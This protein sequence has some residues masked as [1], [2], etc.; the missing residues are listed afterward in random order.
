MQYTH[1]HD[2]WLEH[3]LE[4]GQGGLSKAPHEGVQAH[5]VILLVHQRSL[6]GEGG[7]RVRGREEGGLVVPTVP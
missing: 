7:R 5:V 4:Q 1:A 2:C 6:R 3:P